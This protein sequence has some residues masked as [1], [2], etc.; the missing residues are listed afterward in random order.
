M[1]CYDALFQVIREA[2]INTQQDI[3]SLSTAHW[4]NLVC[5]ASSEYPW[6]RDVFAVTGR[7]YDSV[8]HHWQRSSTLHILAS[9]MY[10]AFN[11]HSWQ[12]DDP[13]FELRARY[14]CLFPREI[15]YLSHQFIYW[16]DLD[17]HWI[18]LDFLSLCLSLEPML[19]TSFACLL[20][21]RINHKDLSWV[22]S[23]DARIYYYTQS[24]QH[25]A[26][27]ADGRGQRELWKAA[28]R[29]GFT[30]LDAQLMR[31]PWLRGVRGEDYVELVKKHP[32]EFS[33]YTRLVSRALGNPNAGEQEVRLWIDEALD[34]VRRLN[35]IYAR[36]QKDL[37][38]KGLEV[39]LGLL[40]TVGVLFAPEQFD[41]IKTIATSAIGSRTL[42]DGI[43]LL[44]GIRG[45][46]GKL[47]AEDFWLLWRLGLIAPSG[48]V[49]R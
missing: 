13:I 48:S 15:L 6:V 28:D 47:N 40:C 11:V 1:K 36:A 43:K 38:W 32:N 16:E 24:K 27:P 2:G 25:I 20:P 12:P 39:G 10:S 44:S 45:L 21:Q 8:F 18:P 49:K 41:T 42:L 7:I 34:G 26:L 4:G 23:G 22:S 17:D 5:V 30:P 29:E 9:R 46:K 19:R 35:M 33:L 31:V 14:A 37:S 3:C